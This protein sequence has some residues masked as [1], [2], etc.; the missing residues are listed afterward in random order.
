MDTAIPVLLLALA[1]PNVYKCTTV[2]IQLSGF[3]P[4]YLKWATNDPSALEDPET[5]GRLQSSFR[6]ILMAVQVHGTNAVV[7][8]WL[9][10]ILWSDSI[11]PLNWLGR[12]IVVGVSVATAIANLAMGFKLCRD[13]YNLETTRRSFNALESR[14]DVA[15][16]L[17]LTADDLASIAGGVSI[18]ALSG[19]AC[20]LLAYMMIRS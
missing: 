7:C 9:A 4:L 3:L 20:T 13:V 6:T 17:N 1:V 19:G 14:S 2:T 5:R 18:Y 11:L 16:Q 15:Q 10:W 8:V 12:G